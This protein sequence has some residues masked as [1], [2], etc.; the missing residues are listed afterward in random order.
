MSIEF[1]PILNLRKTTGTKWT[2][3]ALVLVRKNASPPAYEA[4]LSSGT[5]DNIT[6][7]ASVPLA[8][9]QY[10]AVRYDF[11]I[12][13][14]TKPQTVTYQIGTEQFQFSV[15]AK[16]TTPNLAYV[17]CNGFSSA[18]VM[19]DVEDKYNRW[20]DI[21]NEHQKKNFNILLMGGDQIYSDSIWHDSATLEDWSNQWGSSRW[22]TPFTQTM[23]DEV[24]SLFFKIYFKNFS[25]DEIRSALSCI[26]T[27]MMWDDHDIMDG[28]GSYP[29]ERHNSDVYQG[30][31]RMAEKYFRIFQ[32]QIPADDITVHPASIPNITNYSLGY[33]KMGELSLMVADLRK[34][35]SPQPMKIMSEANWKI[36]YQYLDKIPE[37]GHLIIQS[38]IPVAYQNLNKLEALLNMLPGQ[39]EL[40]DDLRDH[41]RSEAHMGERKR[42]IHRL[43]DY[44]RQKK[45]RVTIVSG[46]VHVGASAVIESTRYPDSS[47]SN[48]I[49]QLISTGVVHPAPSAFVRYLLE[50]N[51]RE[52][53]TIESGITAQMIPLTS[54]GHYLIGERNWLSIEPDDRSRLWANWHVEFSDQLITRVIHPT[55]YKP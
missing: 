30:I 53:E 32:L 9:P 36:F 41:W 38:S 16:N 12:P 55:G 29:F 34:E 27:I 22:K 25:N 15:P 20:R 31:F 13:L 44:T 8:S 45:T 26:P 21:N 6:T 40:E 47:F 18:R 52:I 50:N 37:D 3:S 17:S 54:K 49:N 42:F 10:D 39:A 43:L 7:I 2:I 51:S 33:L 14:T 35:R 11:S 4:A 5:V 19:K 1:G 48:N 23:H 28:W 24:D 46:D